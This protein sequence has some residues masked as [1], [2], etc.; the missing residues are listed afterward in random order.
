MGGVLPGQGRCAV[1]ETQQATSLRRRL[2]FCFQ[3][4]LPS[5]HARFRALGFRFG[6]VAYCTDVSAVP[7]ESWQHLEQLDVL[8]I[9]ALRE[10]PHPT[11]LSINQALEIVE[12]V[13]PRQ[14]YF[15]HIA[16]SLEHEAT[17]A[18][19]PAGV[20]MGYDGLRIPF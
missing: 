19:L 9:D 7:G 18:R 1:R 11:H 2:L 14:T 15:T 5:Q 12:R 16:H 8:V 3:L 10:Q 20:A 6:D 13:K 4:L 17:N